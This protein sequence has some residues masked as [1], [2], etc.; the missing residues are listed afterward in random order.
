MTN[1]LSRKLEGLKIPSKVGNNFSSKFYWSS[2]VRLP[3]LDSIIPRAP[4]QP[5]IRI[6]RWWKWKSDDT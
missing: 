1:R 6:C 3:C 4:L 2:A 5:N